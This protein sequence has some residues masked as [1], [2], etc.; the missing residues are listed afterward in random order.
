MYKNVI[1]ILIIFSVILLSACEDSTSPDDEINYAIIEPLSDIVKRDLLIFENKTIPDTVINLLTQYKA[2]IFG[3]MHTIGEERE[4]VSNLA[5]ELNKAGEPVEL[6]AECPQAYSWIYEKVSIG[7]LSSLPNWVNYPKM[8]P[9]LDSLK[10]YNTSTQNKINLRC[11]DRNEQAN[12]FYNS[13]KEFIISLDVNSKLA[14]Y[15]NKFPH[16]NSSDYYDS[17]YEFETILN[18][19]PASLSLS[20]SDEQFI[21]LSLMVKNE[22]ESI[23]I[24]ENWK[25]DYTTSF[26]KREDLIKSNADYHLSQ[27]NG[28]IIFF[29]GSYHA[30][31]D[32]FLGSNIEWLGDYLHHRNSISQ[33]KSISIVGVALKGE[34]INS[35]NTGTIKFNLSSQSKPDDLFKITADINQNNYSMLFLSDSIFLESN[36]R[37]NYIYENSEVVIPTKKQYDAFIFIPEGTYVGW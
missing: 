22:I 23:V 36:I 29:F 6:C 25:S 3:E 21:I 13:L 1:H 7:E 9:V 16:Y 33:N 5:I 10:R 8:L 4:L 24:R 11:I 26:S 34:I 2:I 20:K 31:K 15:I 30:Q 27:T 19:N 35:S 12:F 17:I 37:T 18:N 14:D 32:R 28:L